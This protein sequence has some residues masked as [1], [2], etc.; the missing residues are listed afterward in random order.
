MKPDKR[1][2]ITRFV[3]S[4]ICFTAYISCFFAVMASAL[5]TAAHNITRG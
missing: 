4:L 5:N 3:L 1:E 2:T